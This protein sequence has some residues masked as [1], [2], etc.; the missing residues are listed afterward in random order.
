MAPPPSQRYDDDQDTATTTTANSTPPAHT[1]PAET[2]HES[3]C[4]DAPWL[5]VQRA[6]EW[7]LV[8]GVVVVL[9]EGDGIIIS[10]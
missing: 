4:P 7:E 10:T 9:E 5:A 3:L 2:H 6:R 1:K 8:S